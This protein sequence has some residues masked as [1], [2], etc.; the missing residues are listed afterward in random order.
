[1]VTAPPPL[2]PTDQDVWSLSVKCTT[3]MAAVVELQPVAVEPQVWYLVGMDLIGHSWTMFFRR[4]LAWRW[5]SLQLTLPSSVQWSWQTYQPNTE[6]VSF[7]F[8][9]KILN[10]IVE[11]MC[12][13]TVIGCIIMILHCINFRS[14]SKLMTDQTDDW[15]QYLD[16]AV[17]ATNT[18]TQS[19]TK[20]T[21]FWMMFSH[22]PHFPLEAEKEG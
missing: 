3:S 2:T 7:V 10:W 14:L 13:N 16:A 15:G 9:C 21:L 4:V 12:S 17:F 5:G 11:Y 20:V 8:A 1:M 22:E 18:S 19:T 6:K